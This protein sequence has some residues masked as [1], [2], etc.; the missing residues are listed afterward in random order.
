MLLKRASFRRST[1]P[2]SLHLLQLRRQG[3]CKPY[4]ITFLSPPDSPRPLEEAVLTL[5]EW[6]Q[7]QQH[8]P[9]PADNEWPSSSLAENGQSLEGSVDFLLFPTL[10]TGSDFDFDFTS[11]ATALDA[12]DFS[13]DFSSTTQTTPAMGVSNNTWYDS[14]VPG[15][16]LKYPYHSGESPSG[17]ALERTSPTSSSASSAQTKSY[18]NFLATPTTTEATSTRSSPKKRLVNDTNNA[19]LDAS[20]HSGEERVHK[21][22]RNTEAARRYRQRKVDKLTE[23]E[24][25]FEAMKQERDDLKL[26]L[27]Q[28]EA[29]AKTLRS[30]VGGGRS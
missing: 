29:D 19:G 12:N 25:A 8:Q 13:T 9:S 26:R 1:R 23:L 22:Q 7:Q 6:V 2:F 27:A 4:S 16:I 14:L 28:S 5:Q 3:S 24:E 21:R 17:S 15:G 11:T 10:F 18:D 30:L 20:P